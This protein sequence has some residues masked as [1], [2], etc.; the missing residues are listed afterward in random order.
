MTSEVMPTA[1]PG[2]FK[3]P[4]TIF[5]PVTC[6][7]KGLC[8]VTEI[9]HQGGDPLESHSLY[10]ELH[11]TGPEKVVFIMGLNSTAAAWLPQVDYFGSKPEYSV[12]VF[13]N[14]G[15]GNSGAP[16]GPYTTSAMAN[17]VIILL[18]YIGWT[19]KRQIHVVGVSLGGMIAQEIAFKIPERIVSLSLVVTK[20]GR[21]R[22]VELPSYIGLK[23]LL[24][25]TMIKEPEQKIPYVLEML[26]PKEWLDAKNPTDSEGRTN[27]EIETVAYKKRI[28]V[29]RPQTFLGA[30]SQMAAA[31]THHVSPDR[32]RKISSAIPKVIIVTGDTDNLIDPSD[33]RFL[34]EHMPEAELVIKVGAAHGLTIQEKEWF[35]ELLERTFKEG[36]ER[37]Q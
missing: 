27:R 4:S 32:L 24:R 7:G 11:G 16:R 8:P 18:N 33:S 29:T 6:T 14:R 9:N 2:D 20:A 19:E 36:R 31:L 3:E 15:V 30:I 1:S 22:L 13:D 10:Y 34:K 17:D 5:N 21:R 23:N 35:N 25:T 12:L 26:Y 28:A 37:A